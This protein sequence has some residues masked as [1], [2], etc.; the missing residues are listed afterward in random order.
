MVD[1]LK[2]PR[3]NKIPWENYG[4]NLREQIESF[5]QFQTK[6]GIA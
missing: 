4:N 2:P 1:K 5:T 3:N 6:G